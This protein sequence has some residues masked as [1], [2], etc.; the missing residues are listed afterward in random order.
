MPY[1][2][3]WRKCT[4]PIPFLHFSLIL[5]AWRRLKPQILANPADLAKRLARGRGKTFSRPPRAWCLAIRAAD[6]RIG[7]INGQI[8]PEYAT[9]PRDPDHP[10]YV[11]QHTITL[12]APLVRELCRP[13]Q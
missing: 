11:I 10:G 13:V 7:V 6:R 3:P 8:D 12:T 9:D 2:S 4:T 1:T 5:D